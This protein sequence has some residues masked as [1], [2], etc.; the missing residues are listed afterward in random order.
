MKIRPISGFPEWLPH[1]R[2]VEQQVIE[3]AR[4]QFE[5]YGFRPIETRAVEPIDRLAHQGSTDKEIYV[6]RRIH[7]RP[8]ESDDA[9]LGLHFDLTVPFARYTLEHRGHLT[10]PFKRYQIQKVWRGERPQEGRYREFYQADIDVIGQD[11]LP[12]LFDAEM[13]LLLHGVMSRLPVPT[14]RIHVG[15]RKLLEGFLRGL[16]I[17]DIAPVL[18]ILDKLPKI[19]AKATGEMLTEIGLDPAA[20]AKSLELAKLQGDGD[21][22]ATAVEALGVVHPLLEQGVAELREIMDGAVHLPTGAVVA[23]LG[24]ARGLDYYTG[25][26]FEGFM[27]DMPA[28]GAVCSGGRYDNLASDA[29]SIRLPGVGVS[30]GIT[31]LLGPLFR[32]QRLAISRQTPTCV[33]VALDRE[34]TRSRSRSVAAMLRARGIPTEVFHAPLKYGKQIRYA[35]KLGIP[36]VW[37]PGEDEGHGELRDIRTGVQTPADPAAWMPEANDLHPRVHLVDGAPA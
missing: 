2:L 7:D 36:F 18:R 30:I 32:R 34:E 22:V 6:L 13:P 23:D 4:Q 24:I 1:E 33:L 35:D 8:E 20:V 26:V 16:G 5:L 14:V 9:R 21:T 27:P 25:A 12:L 15:H 37:F 10:F 29:G 3:T 31:R 17:D 19:G 11:E 28:L